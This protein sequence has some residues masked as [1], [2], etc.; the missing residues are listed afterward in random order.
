MKISRIP[1]PWHVTTWE[2]GPLPR[3]LTS[4]NVSPYHI[5]L[6][7]AA[8]IRTR[9]CRLMHKHNF[10][11]V[12]ALLMAFTVLSLSVLPC[13]CPQQ[14][15]YCQRSTKNLKSFRTREKPNHEPS[16]TTAPP[17]AWEESICTLISQSDVGSRKKGK[18]RE[19]HRNTV[20]FQRGLRSLGEGVTQRERTLHRA[21]AGDTKRYKER[22]LLYT[23]KISQSI[24]VSPIPHLPFVLVLKAP[25]IV[26]T[27][28]PVSI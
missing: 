25:G 11:P 10:Y 17:S 12:T 1:E 20:T 5:H 23:P 15:P 13:N 18:G 24:S 26:N 21:G 22:S 6:C 3:T 7:K 9:P 8:T 14:L 4:A 2:S 27:F 28:L 19:A 16:D